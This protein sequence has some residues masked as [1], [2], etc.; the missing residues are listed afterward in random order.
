MSDFVRAVPVVLWG[1]AGKGVIAADALVSSRV[2]ALATVNLNQGKHGSY[3][4]CSGSQVIAP[5]SLPQLLTKRED[6]L[7]VVVNPRRRHEVEQSLGP[8]WR[9]RCETIA[10]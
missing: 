6:A 1:A 9:D 7:V 8:R 3:L 4:E 5:D 10:N 2:D